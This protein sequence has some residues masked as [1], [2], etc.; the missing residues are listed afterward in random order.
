M[1][2]KQI[3][4]MWIGFAVFFVICMEMSSQETREIGYLACTLFATVAMVLTLK[5]RR[6]KAR[7]T[8]SSSRSDDYQALQKKL[9]DSVKM[10]ESEIP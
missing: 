7:K 3:S 8:Q 1:N 5:D 2:L 9:A 6:Q 4:A 10:G